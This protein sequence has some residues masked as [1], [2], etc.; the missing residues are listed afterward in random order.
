M[1]PGAALERSPDEV[2]GL[3]RP[4]AGA[5]GRSARWRPR[6]WERLGR[7]DGWA[8]VVLV[9]LPVLLY[10]PFSLAGHPVAPG[11]DLA[12]NYPLRL[13]AGEMLR[14]GHL[15]V[16]DPLAWSGTPLLAGWNGGSMFP[17]TWLFAILPG[18][19]AWT[20]TVVANPI[21]AS[22]GAFL[23]LR[24]LSC[25]PAASLVGAL[26]FTYTGFMNGQDVHLGLVQGTAL[27]PW[28]LLAL[29]LLWRR[30]GGGEAR[31][32]LAGPVALLGLAVGATV[33]AGDPRAVTTTAIVDG[34]Y[35]VALVVRPGRRVRLAG[36]VLAGVL[37]GVLVSAVQWLPGIRFIHSSQRGETA[38]T[39]FG[40]GSLDLGHVASFVLVPY[41]FGGNGNFGLP[42]YA[43]SYNLPELTIGT[44]VL[45]TVAFMAFL[46]EVAASSWAWTARRLGRVAPS[47]SGRRLGPWYVMALVGLVL[48][49]G[50]ATPLGHLLVHVPLF[51]GERLQN[52]NA[53]IFDLSLVVLLAFL[54]DDLLERR[55]AGALGSWPARA[56]ALVPLVAMTAL[57]VLGYTD[58]GFLRHFAGV[59]SRNTGLF[60]SMTPVNCWQLALVAGATLLVLRP[61]KVAARAG[62]IGLV[63]LVVADLGLFLANQS[64]AGAP[65]ALLT[66]SSPLSARVARLAGPHGRIAVYNP[67]NQAP[68]SGPHTLLAAGAPDM[69]VPA[70]TMSV[71]GYGSIVSSSYDA[72][73]NTH[74]FENLAVRSLSTGIFDTLD[75]RTLVTVPRYF[76]KSLSAGE[77]LP[78]PGS[79]IPGASTT[80]AAN[81]AAAVVGGPYR[82]GAHATRTFLL[83][84]PEPVWSVSVVLEQH[85]SAAGLRVVL[86]GGR[87][88]HEASATATARR[89]RPAAATFPGGHRADQIHVVNTTGRGVVVEGVVARA[90]RPAQRIALDGPLQGRLVPGHWRFQADFGNLVAYR[91]LAAGRLA[92]LQP[93][94]SSA[95]SPARRLPGRVT[96]HL[97][98][99]SGIERTTISSHH[100]ALLVR[101]ES[102][103]RGWT[104]RLTPDGGGPTRVLRVR[105]LGVVQAVPVPAGRYVITWHYAPASIFGGFLASL[106]GGAGLAVLAAIGLVGGRRHRQAA[107]RREDGTAAHPARELARR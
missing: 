69:N 20:V 17:A 88:G 38:Y 7:G 105:R 75:L 94:A 91:N 41:L 21:V 101:S 1:V 107:A 15:P 26:A 72:A 16:W 97:A 44:G 51:G 57:V 50:S 106:L 58:P 24:R 49:L 98:P 95:A 5:R 89:D 12:Q 63:V 19:A 39:F 30:A 68:P 33:L 74:G 52:R 83:S 31:V 14:S 79:P 18:P 3:T 92:W 48:T 10:L 81:T 43:G 96:T 34:I 9:V 28:T 65:D 87:W 99:D 86:A 45:A 36:S 23:L 40:A 93:L 25:G 64:F 84:S 11:D 62:R 70:G 71:Q 27:M 22:L 37:L 61:E 59:P 8:A 78:A 104:A 77:G 90:G 56:L 73:T 6:P 29:E 35:L 76:G 100:P 54:L 2:P 80:A 46:P 32:R 67:L 85:R 102:Y 82:I 103:S 66:G 4:A 53:A 47:T 42:T 55:R 13:L 60:T